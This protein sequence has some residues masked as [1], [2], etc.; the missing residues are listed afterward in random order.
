MPAVKQRRIGRPR[1]KSAPAVLRSLKRPIKRKQWSDETMVAA[2]EAV[3]GGET[4]LR[5]ARIY[6]VPRSTLQD[7]VHRKVTHGVKPGPRPYLAPAEEKELSMSIVDVAKA[8][9][10]KTRKEIKAI[11][12]K[13]ANEEKGIIRS[14]KVTDG[15]F[16]RFMD[17]HPNLSLCKG[18]ATANVRMDCLNRDTMKQYFSLLKD[19]LQEHGVMDSPAQVYNVDETGMPL[20]HRPPKIV[21]KKGQKTRKVDEASSLERIQH[22]RSIMLMK[23]HHLNQFQFHKG[24]NVRLLLRMT[25]ILIRISAV[26]VSG[27]LKKM[28]WRKL[29]WSGLNVYVSDGYTKTAETMLLMWMLMAKNCYALTVVCDICIC[30]ILRFKKFFWAKTVL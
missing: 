3:K 21:T 27:L 24:R 5:A 28:K 22:Q 1:S 8:G 29:A 19:T 10:G 9:Y 13:V 6:G 12:E 7:R 17:R 23:T 11:A 18:D 16:K 26:Y 14:K 20:D 25:M 2:L 15:W 4:I 30:Y